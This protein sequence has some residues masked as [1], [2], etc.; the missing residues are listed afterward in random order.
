MPQLDYVVLAE[1]VRQDGGTIHIMGA[2]ID[3]LFVPQPPAAV[4][5]GI[6][7]RIT[8]DSTEAAG[9]QHR[10]NIVLQGPDGP[11][12]DVSRH[13]ETPPRP[14]GV[15]EHW[16]TALGLAIRLPLLLPSYGDYSLELIIDGEPDLARSIDLRAAPPP[17]PG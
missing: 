4:Q 14:A 12:M 9:E 13:F 1:Y 3:T 8:F 15:P 6:A 7:S 5:V 2:G 16:Q 11:L 17:E 10:L